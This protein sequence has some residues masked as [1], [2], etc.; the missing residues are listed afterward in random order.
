MKKLS[1]SVN[2][3]LGL[4][5]MASNLTVA[6]Q[7]P[8]DFNGLWKTGEEVLVN[9]IQSGSSIIVKYINPGDCPTG[10][11]CV[12][13]G[14]A[15]YYL[16]GTVSATN[17]LDLTMMRCTHRK[18]MRDEGIADHWTT[19]CKMTSVT[20][21]S[22]SG[23]YRTEWY[24]FDVKDGKEVNFT[25]E[26]SGD[27]D[28]QFSLTRTNCKEELESLV[29]EID[30]KAEMWKQQGEMVDDVSKNFDMSMQGWYDEVGN[31]LKEDAFQ[32]VVPPSIKSVPGAF[33][34]DLSGYIES[35][36]DFVAELAKDGGNFA[37]EKAAKIVLL[38]DLIIDW[39]NVNAKGLVTLGELEQM[40]IETSDINDRH[41]DTWK[42]WV[43]AMLEYNKLRELCANEIPLDKQPR[44]KINRPIDKKDIEEK[45]RSREEANKT[46]GSISSGVQSAKTELT[47][48]AS[49]VQNL[50]EFLEPYRNAD[51]NKTMKEVMTAAGIIKLQNG[52][53]E[54][55]NNWIN[56]LRQL[57]VIDE[58]RKKLKT[59]SKPG[60]G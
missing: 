22:I 27:S 1:S 26:P 14:G 29:A 4:L 31:Q 49:A 53:I 7:P 9:I 16:K 51:K 50:R 15:E 37:L 55:G 30:R 6:S 48:T 5:F 59:L 47:K 25:R 39:T 56:V 36:A 23:T 19:K 41:V 10:H 18:D 35:W 34:Q 42:A 21:N 24:K 40:S 12:L 32:T 17:K 8:L 20:D 46:L 57:K 33:E 2:C 44:P 3:F 60:V 54:A 43:D 58:N 52:L 28:D 13:G 38:A 11:A 45:D